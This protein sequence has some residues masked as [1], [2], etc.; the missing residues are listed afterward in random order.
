LYY[1][2][3]LIMKYTTVILAACIALVQAAPL[4][5]HAANGKIIPDSYIVVLKSGQ[6]ASNFAPKFNT[7]GQRHNGRGQAKPKIL[8]EF[9][10]FPGFHAT[11]NKAAL[12]EIQA[13]AEVEYVEPDAIIT[14]KAEQA[15][16]PS[17]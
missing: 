12:K 11:I 15:K 14:I 7:I 16:P 6:T 9:K 5:P 2:S 3:H 17:W 13:S 10:S 4:V 8:K 1:P